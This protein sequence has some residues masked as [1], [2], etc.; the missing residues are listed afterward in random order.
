M[1][2]QPLDLFLSHCR[3]INP[4]GAAFSCR[5]RAERCRE[6]F[7]AGCS[8]GSFEFLKTQKANNSKASQSPWNWPDGLDPSFLMLTKAVSTLL[9]GHLEEAKASKAFWKR[10]FQPVRRPA[11]CSAFRLSSSHKLSP[12]LA[13]AA[14]RMLL[15]LSHFCSWRWP[16][17]NSLFTKLYFGGIFLWTIIG[18]LSGVSKS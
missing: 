7:R 17:Q 9:R 1:A 4:F 18:S 11:D 15:S 12:M 8:K 10:H 14:V 6:A 3:N 5:G 16:Q 13:R 2:R